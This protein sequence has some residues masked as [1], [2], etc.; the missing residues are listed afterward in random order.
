VNDEKCDL[1]AEYHTIFNSWKNHFCKLLNVYGVNDV[2]QTEI[3]TAEP[4]VSAPSVFNFEMA[5]DKLKI[6]E[7]PPNSDKITEGII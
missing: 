6:Y 5:I 2:R 3:H 4:L 7:S 1:L